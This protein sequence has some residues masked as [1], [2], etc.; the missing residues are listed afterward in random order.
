MPERPEHAYNSRKKPEISDNCLRVGH[1]VFSGS[2]EVLGTLCNRCRT[3]Q[4]GGAL[5]SHHAEQC[6]TTSDLGCM[7]GT[8]SAFSILSDLGCDG[9]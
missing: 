1:P 2:A 9:C 8:Q 5:Q 6:K 4:S 3:L 7:G